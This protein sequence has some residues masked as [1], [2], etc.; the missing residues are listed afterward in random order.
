MKPKMIGKYLQPYISDRRVLIVIS[1]LIIVPLGLFSKAYTGV[2]QA[3]V[4][5]YSGD[6]LYEILWCLVIFWFALPIKDLANLKKIAIKIASWV[7]I[8]TCMIEISQLWFHL[9]PPAVRSH[10]VWRL[11][12]GAGFDWW[13]FV[14][15]ALGSLIGGYWIWQIGKINRSR[16]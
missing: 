8:V 13:D 7:F 10:I 6:I 15:Y 16:L 1:L 12:L 4:Q 11:L 14:H 2:A 5:N 3:W 9:V